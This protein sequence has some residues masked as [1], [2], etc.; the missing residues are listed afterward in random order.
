MRASWALGV[1]KM[2]KTQFRLLAWMK[3]CLKREAFP[4]TRLPLKDQSR[5]I[6][7]RSMDLII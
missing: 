5:R 2:M 1:A 7:P 6:L 3:I 4:G